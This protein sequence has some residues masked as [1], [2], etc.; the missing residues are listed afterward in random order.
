[1]PNVPYKGVILSWFLFGD[2]VS[3]ETSDIDFLIEP[4]CFSEAHEL[5]IADGYKPR[6]YNPDFERQFLDT[7]HELLYRK[8]IGTGAIKIEIHWAATNKMM[9]IPLPNG[10][11]FNGLQTFKISGKEIDI[12]TIENHLLILLVHHGVNDVWRSLRLILDVAAMIE[13]Y[14]VVI[15]WSGF[16]T[17]T[18]KYK[19]RHTT[20]IG[21]LI[22]NQL[23]GAEIPQGYEE[24]STVPENILNNLLTYPAIK[25]SKLSIDNLKQHLFLRD[26]IKDRLTLL[27]NYIFAGVK[28]NVRDWEAVTISKK[29]YGLYYLVKPFRI[30]YKKL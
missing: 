11:L 12:F 18:Q 8:K 25:K 16:K 2:Y 26:S 29:Y 9:N 30:L 14:G 21:F 28:P 20:E 22:A 17:A 5:L 27:G 4:V 15:N 10:Y 13:K 7:S 3:R 6:Y 23:F 19:I 24:K 1:V